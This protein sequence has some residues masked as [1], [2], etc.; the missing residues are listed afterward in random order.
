MAFHVFDDIVHTIH[1]GGC[2]ARGGTARPAQYHGSYAGIGE[3][4]ARQGVAT[5]AAVHWC[6]C[7]DRWVVVPPFLESKLQDVV[8]HEKSAASAVPSA[9]QP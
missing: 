7:A 2:E 8:V 1:G 9:P 4:L 3:V 6:S 5:A